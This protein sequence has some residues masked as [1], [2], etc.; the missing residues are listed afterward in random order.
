MLDPRLLMR[1]W[2][3]GA[4]RI[5]ALALL[6]ASLAIAAVVLMR[7]ELDHRFANRT[8]EAIGGDLILEGSQPASDEQVALV[9]DRPI[10]A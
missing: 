5:Q 9:A 3:S 4:F 8:A 1:P 10:R 6:V 2:R 7:G